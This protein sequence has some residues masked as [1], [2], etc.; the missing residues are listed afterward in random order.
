M[1][2]GMYFFVDYKIIV[3]SVTILALLICISIRGL[4]PISVITRSITT[5]SNTTHMLCD[6][7][8][9]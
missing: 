1:L 9:Q 4:M 5:T 7:L 8:H 3:T 2:Q 6:I